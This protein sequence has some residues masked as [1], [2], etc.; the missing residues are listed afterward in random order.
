[1]DLTIAK[2]YTTKET[3]SI[4]R[5]S[6]Y[7]PAAFYDGQDGHVFTRH[8]GLSNEEM[9]ERFRRA[10]QNPRVQIVAITAFVDNQSASQAGAELLN[11]IYGQE[12]L[13]HLE[14]SPIGTRVTVTCFLKKPVRIR[15]VQFYGVRV[16][17][18]RTFK[19]VIDRKQGI[20][21]FIHVQ[22]F[23]AFLSDNPIEGC[24]IG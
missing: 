8:I 1:M 21:N 23:Y 3:E 24:R 4:F 22:T 16:M 15:Y 17:P 7:R 10:Y 12:A 19:M 9:V 20:D 11:S 2:K 5:A 18:W 6:E 14:C 13:R